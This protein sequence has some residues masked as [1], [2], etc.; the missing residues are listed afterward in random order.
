MT[1]GNIISNSTTAIQFK[2]TTDDMFLMV[3]LEDR[4]QQ[5]NHQR[6]GNLI[7]RADNLTDAMFPNLFY[8]DAR[9]VGFFKSNNIL[10]YRV[11]NT[12]D[13]SSNVKY[14]LRFS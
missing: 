9:L 14:N 2:A 13:N 5:I 11:D 12:G 4:I 3:S 10:I 1:K 8:D 6:D 7:I